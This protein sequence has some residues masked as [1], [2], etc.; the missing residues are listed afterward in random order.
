MKWKFWKKESIKIN[1]PIKSMKLRTLE[2]YNTHDVLIGGLRENAPNTFPESQID[3]EN[4]EKKSTIEDFLLWWNNPNGSASYV[5][6]Y[7]DGSMCMIRRKQIYFFRIVVRFED[8]EMTRQEIEAA[9][10][11]TEELEKIQNVR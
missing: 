6:H 11:K 9:I 3:F 1:K 5:F 4:K 10:K 2:L 8:V 7:Y